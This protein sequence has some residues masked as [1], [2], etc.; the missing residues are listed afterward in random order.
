[1][2]S[3]ACFVQHFTY[4]PSMTMYQ[5]ST[6]IGVQYI[7]N[8]QTPPLF[9]KC[10]I[11]QTMYYNADGTVSYNQTLRLL[12]SLLELL[13][14]DV[15]TDGLVKQNSIVS[16]CVCVCS[17]FLQCKHKYG[18]LE[19]ESSLMYCSNKRMTLVLRIISSNR[20]WQF[21]QTHRCHSEAHF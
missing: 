2:A 10:N 8:N 19:D 20:H 21:S 16:F 18:Q 3:A 12:L 1:M 17:M 7:P 5:P 11:S 13:S 4:S 15:M 9:W 14:G 6:D